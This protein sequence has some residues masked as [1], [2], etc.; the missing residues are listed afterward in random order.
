MPHF[1]GKF[2]LAISFCLACSH[3]LADDIKKALMDTLFPVPCHM[4]QGR[5]SYVYPVNVIMGTSDRRL[6]GSPVRGLRYDLRLPPGSQGIE[7]QVYPPGY[8]TILLPYSDATNGET[9]Q[10]DAWVVYAVGKE[11]KVIEAYSQGRAFSPA[12]REKNAEARKAYRKA[13]MRDNTWFLNDGSLRTGSDGLQTP[14]QEEVQQKN[15]L[16]DGEYHSVVDWLQYTWENCTPIDVLT[17]AEANSRSQGQAGTFGSCANAD[18]NSVTNPGG[19]T[20]NPDCLANYYMSEMR[21]QISWQEYKAVRGMIPIV[22]TVYKVQECL[23]SADPWCY[24]E[25]AVAGAMDIGTILVPVAKLGQGVAGAG[26][27][28]TMVRASGSVIGKTGRGITGVAA[29]GNTALALKDL[30]EGKKLDA[31]ARFLMASADVYQL[32]AYTSAM[33]KM[34]A[35]KKLSKEAPANSQCYPYT[36]SADAGLPSICRLEGR[37][38]GLNTVADAVAPADVKKIFDADGNTTLKLTDPFFGD[39]NN[40]YIHV[41]DPTLFEPFSHFQL[42][43]KNQNTGVMEIL[44]TAP[45]LKLTFKE[46]NHI[47]GGY[48]FAFKDIPEESIAALNAYVARGRR[49][50]SCVAGAFNA[51]DAAGISLKGP[52]GRA[53]HVLP[54]AAM[55][56]MIKDGFKL[57]DEAMQNVSFEVYSLSSKDLGKKLRSAQ[58]G[59]ANAL[60]F[61]VIVVTG[62][63]VIYVGGTQVTKALWGVYVMNDEGPECNA[64]E[65]GGT[66]GGIAQPGGGSP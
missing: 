6:P 49:E 24:G 21:N 22:G 57:S 7:R 63:Y 10:I 30:S 56:K 3:A 29:V 39:G 62:T 27:M 31:V 14:F 32:Y 11:M 45:G 36:K 33:G 53:A 65:L 44:T 15:V 43:V 60:A 34:S 50:A 59:S 55:K 26:R 41:A 48:L 38:S 13:R 23:D 8:K 51:L 12:I 1:S 4:L 46:G 28:A 52:T 47:S 54:G 5:V 25:A 9:G 18:Y 58:L 40:I 61:P 20:N 17:T 37:N 42:I 2:A 35:I 66:P 64:L 19:T 16:V